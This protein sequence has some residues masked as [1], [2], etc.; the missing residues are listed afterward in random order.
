MY[1]AF[2]GVSVVISSSESVLS[3]FSMFSSL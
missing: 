2:D 1:Q 3:L